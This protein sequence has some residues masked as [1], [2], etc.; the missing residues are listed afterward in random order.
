MNLPFKVEYEIAAFFVYFVTMYYTYL[1]KKLPNAANRIY[2]V[3]ITVAFVTT[4]LNI[5]TVFTIAYSQM[6]PVGL[7]YV[8]NYGY[9]LCQNSLTLIWFLYIYLLIMGEN[10]TKWKEMLLGIPGVLILIAFL[11]TPSTGFVFSFNHG[12]EY[13]RGVGMILLYACSFFYLVASI[14]YT[15]YYRKKLTKTQQ[16]AIVSFIMATVTAM[17]IQLIIPELLITGFASA[18]SCMIMYFSLQNPEERMDHTTGIFNRTAAITMLNDYLKQ[19][20][21]FNIVV[22]AIDDFKKFNEKYGFETGDVLLRHIAKFVSAINPDGAYRLDGDNIA[23]VFDPEE[24]SMELVIEDIRRRFY[25]E[26][27]AGDLS[28]KVSTCI[29]CMKCPED[30]GT[31]TEVLDTIN[32][33]ISDAKELG[34]GTVIYASEHVEN[35][36]KRIGE[37][38]E[39][40]KLLEIISREA[41]LARQEA[42]RADHTKSIFLANMSHEIRT[43]M[44]A[45]LGMTE[46][47][48]RE[49]ISDS[50]RD[51]IQNIRAAG[52]S[53]L[54]I[55]NEILDISKIES[56]KLEVINE[57]YYMSSII[58]D[59]SNM[60]CSRLTDKDVEFF[61]EIDNNI[62]DELLGDELRLRQILLN[63]LGNAVK[64][65][66]NGYIRLSVRGSVNDD[67]LTL[68]IDVEDTGF[69]IREE[70]MDALFQNFSRV[71]TAKTRQIEGTGLG[72]TICRQLLT[73]MGG[74]ISVRSEYEKGSVFSIELKQKVFNNH[75]M[76]EVINKEVMKALVIFQEEPVVNPM[77]Y[78][79]N[80]LGVK[81][82]FELES[83]AVWKG[84]E[85]INYTHVFLP[86]EVYEKRNDAIGKLVAKGTK[87]V[88]I[89]RFGE[90]FEGG[91]SLLAI[92]EPIY[93]L[94]VGEALNGIVIDK[95]TKAFQEAF[96]APEAKVLIVD[97]NAVNLKVAEGLLRPYEMQITKALSGKECLALLETKKY[98]L[99][100]LDHMMPEMDG[101]E[102]LK[103]I[104]SNKDL[105]FKNLKVIA[106]TANAIR[107]VREMF[108]E[109]G[110]DDYVSKPIDVNRLEEVLITHLP[111][112]LI[113]S[114]ERKKAVIQEE[115]PYDIPNVDTKKGVANCSGSVRMYWELL[116][117]IVMEGRIKF[118]LMLEYINT[119]NI[120]S[121]MVEAHAL[122]SVAASVGAEELSVLAKE[123]ETEAKAENYLFIQNRAYELMTAYEEFLQSI[124]TVL[125][126]RGEVGETMDKIEISAAEVK[127]QLEEIYG[128]IVGYDDEEAIKVI[129]MLRTSNVS[130]YMKSRLKNAVEALQVLDYSRAGAIIK[131]ELENI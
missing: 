129:K 3:L 105:Y 59:I 115:F 85:T 68:N 78:V 54:T 88:V 6:V 79:L 92:Q 99:V 76:I 131:G 27:R 110:F 112:T 74:E 118:S 101:I 82:N 49:E 97:D 19:G 28:L 18:I 5:I 14:G 124:E 20:Q 35:R 128:Y 33:T 113:K 25:N 64:F 121:Y 83:D 91:G 51:S 30:A 2:K 106:L 94:N 96:V 36:E 10:R 69:G 38:E 80:N 109:C 117:T 70:D 37:L 41:E 66:V 11:I 32:N 86:R 125:E 46:L 107:G 60:I 16:I 50:V 8:L 15:T 95:E 63:L 34:P 71:D 53:L 44:N 130:E 7:N 13:I 12:H 29:C 65:T 90:Y 55:I 84:L 126:L 102:T 77:M 100:F 120:R 73:L 98:H 47:A 104:R 89:T 127:V 21:E 72:L 39:Q 24:I 26:W 108:V 4:G 119:N 43:P 9:L 23:L 67:I 40:K 87:V 61:L 58:H 103:N 116:N 42:E 75:P 122:K 114:T 17:A 22:L 93:C 52:N 62:P 56:G 57:R 123:H 45:I 81:T 111:K 1:G 48:L 31:V